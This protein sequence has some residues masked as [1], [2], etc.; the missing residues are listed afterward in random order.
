MFGEFVLV[1]LILLA[2][3]AAPPDVNVTTG[4]AIFSSEIKVIFIV[5][6]SAAQLVGV[7]LEAIPTLLSVG[8][9]LSKV[10]PSP[11]KV[12]ALVVE[13]CVTVRL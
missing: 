10:T 5:L 3:I 1:K 7:R 2:F 12:V 4:S 11:V 8:E 6:P 9:V 13:L